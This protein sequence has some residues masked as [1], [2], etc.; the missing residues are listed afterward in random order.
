MPC[1][2]EEDALALVSGG[3]EA[4]RRSAAL[5]HLD[6]CFECRELVVALASPDVLGPTEP[7]VWTA[8]ASAS[9]L[10]G[11][12]V[13]A[14]DDVV[15]GHFR[16][17]REVGEGGVG[18]VWAAVDAR[19]GEEVALK[20]LKAMDGQHA[21]RF[22][23]E[24]KVAASLPHEGIAEAREV[25]E[26]AG[27][28]ALVSPLLRGESLD[29][30]LLRESPLPREAACSLLADLADALA[31][32]HARKVVH[33][34]VKPQNVFL[35]GDVGAPI[36]RL[37]LKLLD[38]G[39]AKAL[40]PAF[41]VSPSTRLTESGVVLGTPHYMAPEQILGATDVDTRADVWALGVV[42]YE[43][44]SGRRP[45]EGKSFGQ[46]FKRLTQEKVVPLGT[47]M[48]SLPAAL[49]GLVDALLAADPGARPSAQDAAHAFRVVAKP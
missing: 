23:R 31:F 35:V 44:L 11:P 16:L 41:G 4:S 30:R 5:A 32:A 46:I 21:A 18:V 40:G 48:P 3:L 6:T 34:D 2:D 24:A 27:T 42:A 28:I 33:R 1:L 43:C 37:A 47:R 14:P 15:F 29:R 20:V 7:A 39:L 9:A 38:F 19:T 12:R 13:L 8:S 17:V 10:G 26:E 49:T 45:V 22:R 36:E 25:L